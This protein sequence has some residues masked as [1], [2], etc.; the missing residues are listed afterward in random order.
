M[1][2]QTD[3][4]PVQVVGTGSDLDTAIQCGIER[5]AKIADMSEGETRNRITISGGVEIGR[6]PG[7][8]Q[9]TAQLPL[10]RLDQLGLGDIYR[11]QYGL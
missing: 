2:A 7:V 4:A 11:R 6:V 10:S 1:D 9:V 5:L 3:V 8:V